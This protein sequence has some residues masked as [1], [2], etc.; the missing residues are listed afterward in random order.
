MGIPGHCLA[1]GADHPRRTPSSPTLLPLRRA[2]GAPPPEGPP[3]Q[4]D[5]RRSPRHATPGPARGESAPGEPPPRGRSGH[6]TTPGVEE[7]ADA[8]MCGPA[9]ARAAAS[10]PA[11]A[12]QSRPSRSPGSGRLAGLSRR[13][14]V[15][16]RRRRQATPFRARITRLVANMQANV[17]VGR[18]R[19]HQSAA[20][21]TPNFVTGAPHGFAKS[22]CH[23]GR[24]ADVPN[25]NAKR[26]RA[27]PDDRSRVW[28]W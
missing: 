17:F 10:S 16:G 18:R 26:W 3:R 13:T 14:G 6:M 19:T 21:I 9:T 25:V 4:P 23:W 11:N 20:I 15:S 28:L 1:V 12:V 8:C 22:A 24:G 27:P 2:K 7:S 5:V